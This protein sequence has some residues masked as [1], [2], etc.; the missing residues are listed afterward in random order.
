MNNEEK[1]KRESFNKLK[2]PNLNVDIEIGQLFGLSVI[3]TLKIYMTVFGKQTLSVNDAQIFSAGIAA[4]VFFY[5]CVI[6]K[7]IVES[8]PNAD[9]HIQQL[10][11]KILLDACDLILT[12]TDVVKKAGELFE[13][14]K[15]N[16]STEGKTENE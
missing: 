11:D 7:H 16:N 3:E 2:E 15:N 9:L 13:K 1:M 8:D 12:V 6:D 10:N 4:G 5:N 14:Y